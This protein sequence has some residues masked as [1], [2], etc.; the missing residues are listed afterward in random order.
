[1]LATLRHRNFAL[2]WFAGLISLIGD[3]VLMTALPYY[4]YQQTHSTL[5]TATMVA[6]ELLPQLFLGTVAGVFVDRWDRRRVMIV[7]NGLQ[8]GLVLLL[9]LVASLE[10]LWIVYLITLAQNCAIAFF[11]PA[12]NALLPTLVSEEHLVR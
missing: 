6:A 11:G 5:T 4:V 10:Q 12:E 9:L 8:A 2:L 3:W 1:M 7:A